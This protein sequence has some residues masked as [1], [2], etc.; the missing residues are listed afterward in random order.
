MKICYVKSG[1][2]FQG[3]VASFGGGCSVPFSTVGVFGSVGVY[4]TVR[5]FSNAERVQYF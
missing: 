3:K 4:S 5:V 1:R 2:C